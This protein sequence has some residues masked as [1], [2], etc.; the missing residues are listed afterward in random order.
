MKRLSI[1]TLLLLTTA[2]LTT[3]LVAQ[4]IED[5]QRRLEDRARDAMRSG[6]YEAAVKQLKHL[7][8]VFSKSVNYHFTLADAQFMNGQ[9]DDAVDSYDRSIDLESSLAPRCWQ[10]GL[11][12]YYA[13]EFKAG[14][15]QFELHQTVN[16]QDVENSVW[17][18]LCHAKIAGVEKAREEMIPISGDQRVPMPEVFDLFAGTG[19]IEQVMKAAE[20]A[21]GAT[22]RSRN[23][24]LY[25]AHLYIGLYHEMTGNAD[26]A[27]ESMKKASEVNPISNAQLMGA[28]AD[29]H[30]KLRDPD[31][32]K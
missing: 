21:G 22:E 15:A 19:S 23:T 28:I 25:Y 24:P 12:L 6:D 9:I 13:E 3:P 11:A 2:C 30:L 20:A 4:Q 31:N 18:M 26:E 1:L 10:R 29:I 17:H 32:R 14:K 5:L 27:L 7:T 8:K 16:R